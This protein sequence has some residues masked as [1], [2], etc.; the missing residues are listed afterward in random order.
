[1]ISVFL[2]G[3]GA[4]AAFWYLWYRKVWVKGLKGNLWFAEEY[5]YAGAQA[6]IIEQIENRKKLP[7]PVLELG[8]RINRGVAFIQTE[9]TVVSDFLYKRDIFSLLGYQRI[10]REITVECGKRG[11]YPVDSLEL[12]GFSMFY[13]RKY[14]ERQEVRAA[15]FVYAARTDVSDILTD[16]ERLM[17]TLQCARRL[18]ED[19]FAFH[20]VRE[21]T[22]TDPMRT[23]NW[24]ASARTGEL[25]VNTYDSTL[26]RRVMI[27]LDVEDRGIRRQEHLI[28]ESISVAACLAQRLMGAGVEVGL[29]VNLAEPVRMEPGTQ[30]EL[31]RQMEQTLCRIN[32]ADATRDFGDILDSIP[33]DAFPILITRDG[34]RNQEKL[35][36]FL[37]EAYG[38]W[39]YP[40]DAREKTAV[41]T[42]AN[43]HCITR[44]VTA[45]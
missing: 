15:L 25:M 27:Y 40:Q 22:P 43:L 24:K 35:E 12:R 3:V 38:V 18:Y 26:T 5:V 37:G 28:E 7:V 33:E 4:L 17:G 45:Y 2:I 23:I 19:P 1:M 14:M 21:Y 6:H 11:F 8:F 9:N 36:A 13:G 31:L 39:V 32:E 44:E 16:C 20:A 29:A 30:R 34:K 10:R 41:S 42:R